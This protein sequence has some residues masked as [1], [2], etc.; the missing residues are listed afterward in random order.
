MKKKRKKP[1]NLPDKY[2]LSSLLCPT[3]SLIIA[4]VQENER[5]KKMPGKEKN[6]VLI[7]KKLGGKTGCLCQASKPFSFH[8]ANAIHR[9]TLPVGL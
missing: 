7:P 1:Y 2:C 6:Y 5:F 3:R 4:L 8:T 9:V